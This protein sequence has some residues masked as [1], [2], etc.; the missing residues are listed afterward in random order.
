MKRWTDEST[1][2]EKPD[3]KLRTLL[4]ECLAEDEDQAERKGRAEP[5]PAA[6]L[7][8]SRSRWTS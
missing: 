6:K 3:N 8:T 2:L 7:S 4:F 1:A 5:T